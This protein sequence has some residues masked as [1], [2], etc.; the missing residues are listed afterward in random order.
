MF[1]IEDKEFELELVSHLKKED[2]EITFVKSPMFLFKR[3]DFC[4]YG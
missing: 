3:E 4:T 1:E 2:I